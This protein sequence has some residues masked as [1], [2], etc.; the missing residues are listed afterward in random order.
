M[1]PSG[2]Y[3]PLTQGDGL[4]PNHDGS[5]T[6]RYVPNEFCVLRNEPLSR[7]RKQPTFF[8]SVYS[9]EHGQLTEGS[10]HWHSRGPHGCHD[11]TVFAAHFRGQDGR[12]FAESRRYFRPGQ[13]LKNPSVKRCSFSRTEN[14]DWIFVLDL[15]SMHRAA[16][17]RAKVAKHIHIVYIPAQSTSYCQP[18]DVAMFRTWKSVLTAAANESFTES[19]VDGQNIKT[20]FD[21]SLMHLNRRSVVWAEEGDAPRP[22]QNRPPEVGMET[23]QLGMR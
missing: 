8:L 5:S 2:T 21:F 17:F 4:N 15:A 9:C 18:Y 1:K 7:E 14:K 3:E 19:V 13:H 16:E 23:C 10:H 20:T 6:E 12:V 22:E 11:S